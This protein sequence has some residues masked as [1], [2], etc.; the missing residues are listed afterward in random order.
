M[1]LIRPP[2]QS[3]R[4]CCG[5]HME[6]GFVDASAVRGWEQLKSGSVIDSNEECRQLFDLA[7]QVRKPLF[8]DWVGELPEGKQD[9]EWITRLRSQCGLS[10]R[11]IMCGPSMRPFSLP[12]GAGCNRESRGQAEQEGSKCEVYRHLIQ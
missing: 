2:G 5:P 12:V 9:R 8:G 10:A 6:V 7:L 3:M 4:F 11:A 1:H